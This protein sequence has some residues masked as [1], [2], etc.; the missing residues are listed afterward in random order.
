MSEP[1]IEG[2]T[3]VDNGRETAQAESTGTNTPQ[4]VD[5][6]PPPRGDDDTT[7]KTCR[8]EKI[9]TASS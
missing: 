9:S 1:L 5:P 7:V 4:P 8:V 6:V 2:S 3:V